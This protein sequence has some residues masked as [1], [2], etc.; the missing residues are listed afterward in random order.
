MLA[1]PTLLY[2]ISINCLFDRANVLGVSSKMVHLL[3]I[4]SDIL[5]G[6]YC[7]NMIF[8]FY[9]F[10][11]QLHIPNRCV[12]KGSQSN[13]LGI[14]DDQEDRS[15]DQRHRQCV[16]DDVIYNDGDVWVPNNTEHKCATCHC[17]V[18]IY[19]ELYYS[20]GERYIKKIHIKLAIQ[21]QLN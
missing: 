10:C 13:T 20:I 16:I 9:S 8:T 12:A 14:L 17:K 6:L 21:F 15:Q 1:F 18:R 5:S 7:S 2:V 11:T 3:D 19:M 4:V